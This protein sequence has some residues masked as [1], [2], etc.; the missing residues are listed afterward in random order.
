MSKSEK[1]PGK[2]GAL[3][4]QS[5]SVFKTLD[6]DPCFIDVLLVRCSDKRKIGQKVLIRAVAVFY[7]PIELPR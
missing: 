6:F 2:A 7:L 4:S 1:H 3:A 5:K